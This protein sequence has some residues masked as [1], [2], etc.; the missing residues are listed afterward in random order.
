MS[1]SAPLPIVALSLLF[2]LPVAAACGG[3]AGG[4]AT[5]LEAVTDTL[6]GV[7]RL[8]YPAQGAAELAWGFDTTAVIGG[9][10]E[11]DPDYQFGRL[12]PQ[13]LAS[14]AAGNLY[15]FDTDGVRILG[16]GPDGS[17][18]G[19]WGREGGG[20]GEI[21]GRFIGAIAM[22]PGDTLW[23]AD[24]S[25]QRFTLIPTGVERGEPAS[26]PLG[27]SGTLMSVGGLAVD[28]AGAIALVS[29]FIFEPDAEELPPQTLQRIPRGA[30]T[31]G[32]GEVGAAGAQGAPGTIDTL[33]T[34]PPR[35]ANFVT[36]TSGNQRM[37]LLNTE[38][39]QPELSWARF[40]DGGLAVQDAPAYE[41]HLLDGSGAIERIIR[42]DPP[43]RP[44]T[45]ADRQAVIDETLAPP[46]DGEEDDPGAAARRK[47]RADA[48][49]FANVIPRIVELRIDP[50]DR[51]WVGISKQE[52]GEIERIDVY[53]REGTLLGELHDLPLPDYFFA[54]DRAVILG[55]DEFEVQQIRALR[56][57]DE[58]EA[59]ETASRS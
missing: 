10:T 47:Q 35:R 2:V 40:S 37:I 53:D 42:R 29:S 56:L 5:I 20:P 22:G 4:S 15:V 41:I 50:R 9:Y 28:S 44:T 34:A 31:S 6:D 36:I 51:L 38:Q 24:R 48:M 8:T 27:E 39:F 49:T 54:E 58:V 45:Q 19:T 17:L 30:E 46:D 1:P 33:W 13:W 59:L 23:I 57:V 43:P 55:T 12:P 7:E 11:D 16:Y 26:V 32:T 21:G 25:N 14:D 18:L 52:P 3:E